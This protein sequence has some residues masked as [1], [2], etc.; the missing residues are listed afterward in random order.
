[1]SGVFGAEGGNLSIEVGTLLATGDSA[2]Q[3]LFFFGGEWRKG[4]GGSD[5]ATLELANVTVDIEETLST[6]F[7]DTGKIAPSGPSPDSGRVAARSQYTRE[8][9]P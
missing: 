7:N 8:S 3:R 9:K 4:G 2:I 1:M 5:G 6:R